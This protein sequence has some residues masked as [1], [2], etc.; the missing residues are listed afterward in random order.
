MEEE[1]A[2]SGAFTLDPSNSGRSS[3]SSENTSEDTNSLSRR[4]LKEKDKKT[5]G[6]LKGFLRYLYLACFKIAHISF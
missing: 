2:E 4:K 5:S 3:I 1:S 6:L